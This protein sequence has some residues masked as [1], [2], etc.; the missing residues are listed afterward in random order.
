[1]RTIYEYVFFK[2]Y[3]LMLMTPGRK[4]ADHSAIILI[5]IAF[6]FYS[7]PLF[8]L[9]LEAFSFSVN[10]SF[11]VIAVLG[12]LYAYLLLKINES[13]FLRKNK[14]VKVL[15]RF[16]GESTIIRISG[17]FFVVGVWLLCFPAFFILLK[18]FLP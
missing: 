11:W 4:T 15:E 10:M 2:L 3:K 17:Y 6:F 16:G 18:V 13:Y 9:L 1:M 5:C 7:L 8:F 14:I 12:L